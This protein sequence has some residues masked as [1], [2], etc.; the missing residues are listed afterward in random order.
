[1]SIYFEELGISKEIAGGLEAQ[2]INEPT[3]IQKESIPMALENKNIIGRSETGSG[4]TLAYLLPIFQRIDTSKREM[5]AIILAPTHELVMQINK[6]IELLSQNSGK[7]VTSI[8][9]I[10]NVNI[11]KQVEKLRNKQHIIVGS[12]VRIFQLIKM[13]KIH[14][15]TV[16]TIVIDE[17]DRLLDDDNISQVKA[18][19]K[20]VMRDT[21]VMIFSATINEKTLNT[22]KEILREPEIIKLEEKQLINPNIEHMYFVC[23]QRDKIDLLRKLIAS[24]NPEKAIIFINKTY[25][26]ELTLEKLK[27][28]K[29]N[30]FGLY[31]NAMKEERKKALCDF[32]D[33]KIQLLVASDLAARGLDIE[34]VTHI[35]NLDLPPKPKEYLHRIGRTGRMGK[36]GT[37]ISIVEE[38]EVP[39]IKKYE[40]AFDIK[41]E[42][43]KINRGKVNKTKNVRN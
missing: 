3:D 22:A 20:T 21:Q 43:S 18:V 31:G 41:I 4:K 9:I 13:K 32:R 26:I 6:Q 30:V 24:I 27:Y 42:C 7:P 39:L 36:I 23:E 25:E 5:Q 40:R 37:A 8:P 35:F 11:N 34:G 2:G 16:K 14:A 33:G 12:T 38:K 29:Y 10:G 19:L 15:H 17:G 1:M 28:H